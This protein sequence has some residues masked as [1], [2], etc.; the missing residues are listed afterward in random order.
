MCTMLCVVH[1]GWLTFNSSPC[2]RLQNSITTLLQWMFHL[3]SESIYMEKVHLFWSRSF[4][5]FHFIRQIGTHA[6]LCLL[7]E[8][9]IT[10]LFELFGARTSCFKWSM[11]WCASCTTL[12]DFLNFDQFIFYCGVYVHW[13]FSC[14]NENFVRP[15]KLALENQWGR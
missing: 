2:V 14:F 8:C 6:R 3:F 7:N 1:I 4:I 15:Y 12:Y 9:A 5:P 11:I 13:W 10:Y